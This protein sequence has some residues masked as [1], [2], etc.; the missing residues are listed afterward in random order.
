MLL[1]FLLLSVIRWR[2]C[3]SHI[4]YLLM[5]PLLTLYH[6]V[7]TPWQTCM[8]VQPFLILNITSMWYKYYTVSC[9]FI[10]LQKSKLYS[11]FIIII[12]FKN[13]GHLDTMYAKHVTVYRYIFKIK[14]YIINKSIHR[15]KNLNFIYWW[16]VS[17]KC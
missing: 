6:V 17:V 9:K 11:Q 1:F 3:P 5:M 4:F 14:L 12:L 16:F 7:I 2:Y 10:I 15:R 8:L 13:N